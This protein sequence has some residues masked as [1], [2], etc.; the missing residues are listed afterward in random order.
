MAVNT[1]LKK[2]E[3]RS[4]LNKDFDSLRA[5]LLLYAK[6]F[7][8]DKM[9]DFSEAS[10]G[11]LLLD[12]TAYVGDVMSYYLDYQFNELDIETATETQNIQRLLRQAG[13][14]VS[15]ASPASADVVFSIKV[16]SSTSDSSMP[17]ISYL[18]LIR[19]GTVLMSSNGIGFTLI[20]DLDFGATDEEGNHFFQQ[21]TPYGS[22]ESPKEYILK[23]TGQCVSGKTRVKDFSIGAKFVPFRRIIIPDTDVSEIIAVVDANGNEYHEVGSLVQNVVYKRV[24][25][26]SSDAYDVPENLELLPAPYRY[27]STFN[28]QT[29]KTTIQFG[30][31]RADTLDDDIIPDPS[32]LSLPMYGKKTI[33]RFS[34]DPNNLLRTKSL[35]ISPIGTTITVKYRCG[36]GL[37]HNVS[38]GSINGISTLLTTFKGGV[39]PARKAQIRA[40]V[41]VRNAQSAGGGENQPS[42]E[43]L[44][45]LIVSARN[46]QSRIV[47][48]DDLLSHVYMMPSRFGRIFR[49]GIRSNSD[50]PL[51]TQLYIICRDRSGKLKYAPDSLKD[52]LALWLNQNRLI[53]DAID[54]LDSPIVDVGVKYSIVVNSV[55]NKNSVIQSINAK[56][57]NYF[58]IANFQID[59]PLF[60]TEIQR[61]IIKSGGV[62]SLSSLEMINL[63]GTVSNKIYSNVI[64]NMEQATFKGIVTP[65][66]GGIFQMRYPNYDIIG[67]VE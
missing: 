66:G 54:I 67:S 15:G 57:K 53:S 4:Y 58:K 37:S 36:G 8:P 45:R 14:Q 28:R 48:R 63:S 56:I 21:V 50:N 12:M 62:I 17:E 65:P 13:V 6:T 25:N 2:S 22:G 20:S 18:P 27:V 41:D 16:P 11:G 34:I 46:A 30:S 47:T 59:Q 43:D 42:I 31:G 10:L 1:K 38:P 23:L 3:L 64:L 26:I 44:K 55:A 51:A 33:S 19:E 60:L 40:S 29:G 9:Q 32:E 24:A 7:F 49:A 61:I 52:N 5:D 35:G 39:S